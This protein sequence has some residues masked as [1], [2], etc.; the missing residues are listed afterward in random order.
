MSSDS[1]ITL[2]RR[3]VEVFLQLL[4]RHD[5]LVLNRDLLRHREVIAEL[6]DFG[7]M[8]FETFASE[9]MV[10]VMDGQES[11]EVEIDE[12]EKVARFQCPETGNDRSLPLHEIKLYRLLPRR[13]CE[14]IAAQLETEIDPT[15]LDAPLIADEFW[16][17]GNSNLGGAN[18]P[19]FFARRL[20]RNL[21][22]VM[23]ALEP[24]SDTEGGLVLYS[25][26]SPSPH[27]TLPGRHFAVSLIDALSTET[28]DAKLVRSY[29]ARIVS[30]LPSDRSE[31]L[32]HFDIKSGQLVIRGRQ[33]VFKGVQRDIIG[34]LWKMR[35]SDQAGFTWA[36]ISKNS[37]ANSRGIDDA[38]GGKKHRELW[39]HKFEN[40]HC[41]LRRD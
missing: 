19:V 33:K 30:G 38:F 40:G 21:N 11:V 23:S 12:L 18:V 39:I 36:E 2:S 24:R 9:V 28:Q 31:S 3:A 16:F 26:Q 35:E 29:L 34:W 4:D 32:F 5:Q 1:T 15:A 13:F 8:A 25:G 17:L 10:D 37:H 6:M 14:E 27:L 20:T 7:V 22:A 41:R